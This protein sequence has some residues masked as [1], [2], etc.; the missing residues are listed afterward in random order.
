MREENA[1]RKCPRLPRR[2]AAEGNITCVRLS[3]ASL[4][5]N[6]IAVRQLLATRRQ[7]D[8]GPR[9]GLQVGPPEF[10][11]YADAFGSPRER[12]LVS[13]FGESQRKRAAAASEPR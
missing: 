1:G 13:V 8:V 6:L 3:G 11:D 4:Q 10:S 12:C 2:I 7:A 9:D 5:R